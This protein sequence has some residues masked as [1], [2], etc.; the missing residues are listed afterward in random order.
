MLDSL[1]YTI[2]GDVVTGRLGTEDDVVTHVLLDE[3]I[4][5]V[6]ADNWVGQVHVFDLGLQLAAVLFRDLATEDDGSRGVPSGPVRRKC[7]PYRTA[8]ARLRGRGSLV[9]RER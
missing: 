3:A 4:A 7:S 6:T 2:V 8:A 1:V 9:R 5:I